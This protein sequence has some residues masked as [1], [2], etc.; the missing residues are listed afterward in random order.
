MYAGKTPEDRI[1]AVAR[2]LTHKMYEEHSRLPD[3]ADFRQALK[4]FIQREMVLARID[5]AR[6][7]GS[8]FITSRVKALTREL[9]A[10][11]SALPEDHRP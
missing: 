8:S 6:V 9:M 2:T 11:E 4:P 3:Y 5:E 1:A 10:I 7:S